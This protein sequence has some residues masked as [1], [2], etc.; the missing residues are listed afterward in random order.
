MTPT[1]KFVSELCKNTFLSFWSFPNPIGKQ[2]DK[3]LC[4]ILV[5]C[6][7]DIIIFSIKEIII[8]DSGKYEIDSERWQRRAIE[9]SV[10]QIYG[11]ERILKLKEE[12]LLNDRITKI[13]LPEK[14]IRKIYRV[15]VAF[16]RGERF[17]LKLGD[18]GKGFVHVFDEKSIQIIL[19]ELDTISDFTAFLNAKEEFASKKIRH[20]AFSGEDYLAMYLQ[21]SFD[22]PEGVNLLLIDSDYWINYSKSREFLIEKYENRI[23]YIWDG[24]IEQLYEDFESNNLIDQISRDELEIALR[25]MNKETRFGRR[26]MSVLLMEVLDI[27]YNISKPKARIVSTELENSPIYVLMVRPHNDREFGRRELHLRCLVAR[28]ISTDKKIVIGIGTDPYI[29]GKGHSID[30]IYMDLTN[31]KEEDQLEAEKIKNKFGYFKSPNKSIL[32][33]NGQKIP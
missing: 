7:P 30:L 29:E 33:P 6:E 17:S 4:D 12:V 8:K 21:N 22:I 19:E 25:F 15:A 14:G 2:L 32:K 18:F 28:S 1:E 11:A 16:G 20:I 9:A 26:Q 13:T 23:S 27:D 31:W 5:V 3:E 24:I 10:E